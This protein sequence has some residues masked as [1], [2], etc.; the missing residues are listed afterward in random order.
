MKQSTFWECG[1]LPDFGI[2]RFV[3]KQVGDALREYI[4]DAQIDLIGWERT[5]RINVSIGPNDEF[6]KLTSFRKLVAD[7]LESHGID[8]QSGPQDMKAAAALSKELRT[9]SLLVER[10]MK[11]ENWRTR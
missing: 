5:R 11:R 7:W 8:R 3:D 4:N 9:C 1:D 2:A 10:A 6:T